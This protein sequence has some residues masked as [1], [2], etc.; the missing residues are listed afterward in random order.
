MPMRA[1]SEVVNVTCDKSA[2]GQPYLSSQLREPL[3]PCRASWR[4]NPSDPGP[5][6]A[7]YEGGWAPSRYKGCGGG[8][9][10][11]VRPANFLP[12]RRLDPPSPAAS[13]AFLVPQAMMHRHAARRLALGA[14]GVRWVQW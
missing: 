7:V 2:D 1:P 6:T 13:R 14:F 10:A 12:R 9:R 8:A 11:D 5:L 4:A 3:A